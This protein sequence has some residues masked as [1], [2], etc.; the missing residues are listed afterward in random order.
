MSPIISIQDFIKFL[1]K[2][3]LALDNSVKKS[4]LFWLV[5]ISGAQF[6]SILTGFIGSAAL[7]AFGFQGQN[8]VQTAIVNLPS[9][10]F[11]VLVAVQA[12]IT[13]EIAFRLFLKPSFW[14][15]IVAFFGITFYIQ[16]TLPS[17]LVFLNYG[18][19]PNFD[20]LVSAILNSLGL[21]LGL[22]LIFKI[23]PKILTKSEIYFKKYFAVF[24][25]VS[26]LSF[27]A[28]HIQNYSDLDWL[29][30]LAP[31]LVL[32]QI[33]IG[34]V[35]TYLRVRMGFRWGILAHSLYNSVAAIP[36]L[37]LS[38]LPADIFAK[39]LSG[40]KT[41]SDMATL[42]TLNPNQANLIL[43]AAVFFASGLVWNFFCFVWLTWSYFKS[44]T[45]VTNS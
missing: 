27:G 21:A 9:W 6:L 19:S 16:Q 7:S 44:K 34:F 45:I 28:I 3:S 5:L 8:S 13:E 23:R 30:W 37:I 10:L 39:L 25:Y 2:P 33:I 41:S 38:L 18:L 11:F 15:W 32:P 36:I 26:A 42:S 12:P 1:K 20:Y 17:D 35:I 40:D 4:W 14:R 22:G 43:L 24:C 29:W 31:L